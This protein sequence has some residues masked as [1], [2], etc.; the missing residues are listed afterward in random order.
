MYQ[1]V[2]F[3]LDGTLLNTLA[4]LAA[5]GNFALQ[6]LGFPVH[7]VEKYRNFVGNGIPTLIQRILPA[8]RDTAHFDAAL[9]LFSEYYARHHSDRTRPYDGIPELLLR[10]RSAGVQLAVVTNKDHAFSEE[11]IRSFFGSTIDVVC[12]SRDGV[13][14][15][16][17]PH[18]VNIVM[19]ALNARREETLYVGDSNVDME[20]AKNAGLDAC[21]VLWGFRTERELRESGA[22]FLAGNAEEL[23][24]IITETG[25]AP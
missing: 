13:P 17:D 14:R 4:D 5:A 23:Y 20:T 1:N 19:D 2:I 3:D 25:C 22:M 12:G 6:S 7:D 24:H 18:M 16:P 21:G 8:G 15:K 9:R 10:L 11:L